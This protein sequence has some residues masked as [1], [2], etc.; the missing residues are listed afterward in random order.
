MAIVR[1]GE[2]RSF[3]CLFE[4]KHGTVTAELVKALTL[5]QAAVDAD[6]LHA[7]LFSVEMARAQLPIEP[8]P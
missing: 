7:G 5:A 4:D 2:I 8:Q 1:P 3:L 6:T